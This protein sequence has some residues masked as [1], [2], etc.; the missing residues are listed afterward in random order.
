MFLYAFILAISMDANLFFRLDLYLPNNIDSP[1][2]VVIFVT[3]GAWII[4]YKAWGALLGLQLAERDII[5]ASIDYR[6]V[7][8]FSYPFSIIVI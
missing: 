5:V 2:P 1:K 3:G 7:D 8:K 6:C 4:G